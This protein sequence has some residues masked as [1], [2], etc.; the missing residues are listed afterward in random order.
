MNGNTNR[1][2]GERQVSPSGYFYQAANESLFSCPN[3]Q[4]PSSI[5]CFQTV[6]AAFGACETS[7]PMSGIAVTEFLRGKLQGRGLLGEFY[8]RD[9]EQ[10]GQ[11]VRQIE[12]LEAN[13]KFDRPNN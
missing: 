7:G 5:N 2:A 4:S 13:G 11:L 3:G 10:I 8:Y 1:A 9:P 12:P 6:L